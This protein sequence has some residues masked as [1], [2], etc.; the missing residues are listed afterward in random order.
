MYR[1]IVADELGPISNY[2]LRQMPRPDLAPGEV[3]VGLK[4]IGISYA[5]VLTAAGQYQVRPPV[6]FV[7]GSEAAG[8][9][10]ETGSDVTSVHPG[11]HVMVGGWYGQYAEECVVPTDALTPVPIG[12]DLAEASVLSG[13]YS[14]AWHA[15]VDRANVQPGE[16]VLVL[17]AG[18]ATG[19]AA[20]QVAKYLGAYVIG[21]ASS[22]EK[23]ALAVSGGADATVEARAA[24]W[25]ELVKAANGGKP[26]DVVFDPVGGDLTEAA[27]RSL[28]WR[29]RHLIIGFPAGIASVRTNLPLLKGAS[30]IGVN[31][32]QFYISEPR[33]AAENI[34]RVFD[35]ANEKKFAP[36]IATRYP[37]EDFAKAMAEVAGGDSAGRILLITDTD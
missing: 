35:L 34:A 6:P 8:I 30:L 26:V 22:E 32:R 5:D 17:G 2:S 29:G 18:G 36:A 27:F 14:T 16:T 37:L 31:I 28:A 33:K 13:S 12:I 1:A 21:S 23:R 20:V 9:V 10:I 25:R 11:D 7:P 3:R 24:D 19:Y 4:A 15:L